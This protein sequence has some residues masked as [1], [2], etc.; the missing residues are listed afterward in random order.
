MKAWSLLVDRFL[1]GLLGTLPRIERG[2]ERLP[3][4]ALTNG[5]VGPLEGVLRGCE[6]VAGVLIGPGRACRI[7]ASDRRRRRVD[8]RSSIRAAVVR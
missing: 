5:L 3:V 8:M 1:R 4:V 6:L 2:V 7:D